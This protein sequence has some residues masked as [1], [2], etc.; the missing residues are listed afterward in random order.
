L[1]VAERALN[2]RKLAPNEWPL[3]RQLYEDGLRNNNAGPEY[4]YD[5]NCYQS[6]LAAPWSVTW[7]AEANNE[8]VGVACFLSSTPKISH[9]HL[10]GGNLKARETNANYLLLENAFE[11]FAAKGAHV[12]H[13]GG[14]RTKEIDDDL[15]RFKKRFSALR[16]NFYIAGLIHDIKKFTQ[17]GGSRPGKFIGYR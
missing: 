5:D 11:Y 4:F 6:L 13:L 10:A 9:Y 16:V 14:G 3:F 1:K 12:M 7:V 8:P 15:F 2:L 17:L